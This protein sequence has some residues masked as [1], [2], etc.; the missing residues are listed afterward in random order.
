MENFIHETLSKFHI[1]NCHS[2]LMNDAKMCLKHMN[3]DNGQKVWREVQIIE[4]E[5]DW[6]LKSLKHL[7]I[8]N[9]IC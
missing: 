6:S 3:Y 9:E 2:T 4:N 1:L 7:L 8:T 5:N